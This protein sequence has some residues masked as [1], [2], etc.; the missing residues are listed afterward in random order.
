[1][2]NFNNSKLFWKEIKAITLNKNNYNNIS[3]EQFFPYFKSV[4]QK[5]FSPPPICLEPNQTA[6]FEFDD[7][8]ES[9]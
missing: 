1:M 3:T 2:E 9:F 6:Y 7:Q 5:D 4:F 8:N